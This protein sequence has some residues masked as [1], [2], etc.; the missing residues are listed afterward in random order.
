MNK[1]LALTNQLIIGE[2][3]KFGDILTG[4]CAVF[5]LIQYGD[6][7][8]PNEGKIFYVKTSENYAEFV[9]FKST[10]INASND[11]FALTTEEIGR[12]GSKLEKFFQEDDVV[13]IIDF[14]ET[15]MEKRTRRFPPIKK[16]NIIDMR[17]RKPL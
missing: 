5:V 14:L 3:Y 10:F 11:A 12:R 4:S 2:F 15:D 9:C 17:T 7:E 13:K 1:T 6:D 8:Q 16:H